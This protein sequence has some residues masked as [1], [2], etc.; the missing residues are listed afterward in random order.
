RRDRGPAQRGG[1]HHVPP[2]VPGEL[3]GPA[4]L[5]PG[6]EHI[7]IILGT[8]NMGTGDVFDPS[9]TRALTPGRVPGLPPQTHHFVWTSEETIGQVHSTGPW[10]V[11]Y[12]NPAEDPRK[13]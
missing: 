10:T 9:K 11:T 12:V 13:K 8:L 7:T 1:A 6:I 5:H 3:Q 4:P 2:E